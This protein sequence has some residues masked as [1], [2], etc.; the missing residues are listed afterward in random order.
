MNVDIVKYCTSCGK[1]LEVI[2]VPK[3]RGYN[4]ETGKPFYRIFLG[5]PE[6]RWW[7]PFHS[8]EYRYFYKGLEEGKWV[9]S[10]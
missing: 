9:K 2:G 5:C 3:I 6:Y 1:K 7:R 8:T 10:I 4:E